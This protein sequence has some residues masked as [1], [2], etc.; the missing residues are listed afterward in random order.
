[1]LKSLIWSQDKSPA[2]FSVSRRV[3]VTSPTFPLIV[4][5]RWSDFSMF[6]QVARLQ[7]FYALL[8][9]TGIALSLP[10]RISP[11]CSSLVR[12]NEKPYR[13]RR[14]VLTDLSSRSRQGEARSLLDPRSTPDEAT[15]GK[16]MPADVGGGDDPRRRR[17]GV[18][19]GPQVQ[20]SKHIF[21][22]FD[23]Q[24]A[25]GHP[26]LG[27]LRSLDVSGFLSLRS[28]VSLLAGTAW[29]GQAVCIH[30]RSSH[31]PT[32]LHPKCKLIHQRSSIIR[33]T[34]GRTGAAF[35]SQFRTVSHCASCAHRLS[36][37]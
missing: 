11:Q 12:L 4:T 15:S 5:L 9:A 3:L 18:I 35:H 34:P 28:T 25:R 8:F 33:T 6:A 19:R 23:F 16:R 21:D 1:M 36:C 26:I 22:R 31:A 10:L 7:A 14:T 24:V 20:V 2:P 13:R 27:R 37:T 32:C 17:T 29:I 30:S